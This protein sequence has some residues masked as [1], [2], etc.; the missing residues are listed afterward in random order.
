AAIETD[1]RVLVGVSGHYI[2]FKVRKNDNFYLPLPFYHAFGGFGVYI[3]ETCRYL[4][5]QP[6]KPEDN[7]HS[8]RAMCGIGLRKEF[9]NQFKTRFAIKHIYEFYG[10]SEANV[11]LVNL[12]DKEGS[13]GFIPYYY[14]IFLRLLYSGCIVKVDSVTY[15]PIRNRKGLCKMIRPG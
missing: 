6:P 2:G 11:Y 7:K 8:I 10:A 5:S 1:A 3:G 9:W 15:E 13:C 4:L 12:N 14:G